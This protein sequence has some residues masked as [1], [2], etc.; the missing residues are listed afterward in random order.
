MVSNDPKIFE[1]WGRSKDLFTPGPYDGKGMRM[2]G[3]VGGAGRAG[4]R[5]A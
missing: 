1:H 2:I 4:Y 5:S 3:E